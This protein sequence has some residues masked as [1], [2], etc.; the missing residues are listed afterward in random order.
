[1]SFGQ[2]L[3]IILIVLAVILVVLYFLGRRNEKKQAETQAQLD[4]MKQVCSMLI[5]DKKKLRLKQSG[6]PQA[7]IDQTPAYLRWTKMPIVKAKVGPKIMILAA[8]RDVWEILPV[9]QEV[10]VEISGIYI[11]AIKSVRGGSVLQK[12]KKGLLAKL[13][14]KVK[15]Q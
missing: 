12:Q 3:T 15:K 4:A 2:I 8:D 10:K 13:R 1:M 6:L 14:E 5:I 9:K 11:T 7:V